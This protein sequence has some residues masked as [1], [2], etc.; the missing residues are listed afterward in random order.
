MLF[1]S[2]GPDASAATL[3]AIPEDGQP[4]I[5]GIERA[6]APPGTNAPLPFQ[7]QQLAPGTYKVFAVDRPDYFEYGNPEVLRKYSGKMR[8]I[9]LSPNQEGKVDLELLHI[10]E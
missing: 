3:I 1:R 7:M 6:L 8:E 2:L 4:R 9:T 5:E 10:G